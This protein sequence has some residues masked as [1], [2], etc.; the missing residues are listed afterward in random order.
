MNDIQ[1]MNTNE[2]DK[3]A[4]AI[5]DRRKDL[6]A[7]HIYSIWL[8]NSKQ[9]RGMSRA[10][11]VSLVKSVANTVVVASVVD[12]ELTEILMEA[13]EHFLEEE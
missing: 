8:A 5:G 13:L 1:Y 2:L 12:K 9:F 3:T 4:I 7:R 11:Q 6:S 10:D